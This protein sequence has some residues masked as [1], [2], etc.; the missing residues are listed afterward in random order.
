[1][2]AGGS[3]KR[4]LHGSSRSGQRSGRRDSNPR[5]SPWQGD[6]LPLSHFRRL[7]TLYG[8]EGRLSRA[9]TVVCPHP[10]PPPLR[11]G[12]EQPVPPRRRPSVARGRGVLPPG[13]PA[14]GSPSRLY[15]HEGRLSRAAT[16]VCPHPSPPP[17][18][19]GREQPVP[20][21]RRPSVAR[22]RGVHPPGP[23][24]RGSPSR[25]YGHERWLSRAA[26][27]VCP[28]PSPP[29]SRRLNTRHFWGAG[30]AGRRAGG[31][32]TAGVPGTAGA[33]G[34]AARG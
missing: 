22:G 6:A 30:V 28:H 27:V 11:R 18:R 23:P 9:A 2:L 7:N 24:G 8:H 13:P 21:R 4:E 25:L 34:G 14:R 19:R 32:R 29:P 26:T 17:L 20:P 10:S 12:R 31:A 15:G 16:V 33:A 5:P 1:M 3:K